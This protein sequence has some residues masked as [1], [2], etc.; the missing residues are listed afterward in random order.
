MTGAYLRVK[1]NDKWE[2]I[3]IDQMTDVELDALAERQP[4]DGWVW[5]KY[6]AKFIRDKCVEVE[7]YDY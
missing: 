5:A 1:R 6:L 4:N 2:N 7:Q 3:E